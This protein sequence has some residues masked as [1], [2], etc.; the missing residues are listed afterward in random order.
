MSHFRLLASEDVANLHQE[1]SQALVSQPAA[2]PI[3]GQ[4]SSSSSLTLAFI[5]RF[6]PQADTKAKGL[7][8]SICV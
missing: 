6:Y 8:L 5:N 1:M 3:D 2:C 4:K 7:S